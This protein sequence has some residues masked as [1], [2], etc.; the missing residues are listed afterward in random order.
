VSGSYQ[1]LDNPPDGLVAWYPDPAMP[2]EKPPAG[3]DLSKVESIE[4][5]TPKAGAAEQKLQFAL[6]GQPYSSVSIW[7]KRS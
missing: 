2:N 3:Q 7:S 1:D 6:E 5:D 4:A